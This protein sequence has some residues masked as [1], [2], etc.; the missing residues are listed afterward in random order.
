MKEI[1]L[2]MK[3]VEVKAKVRKLRTGIE[4]GQFD[5]EKDEMEII[6]VT[7]KTDE[8]LHEH[9]LGDPLYKK[10]YEDFCKQ[11]LIKEREN[12]I[13]RILDEEN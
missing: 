11:E 12:K 3:S 2:K 5:P 8:E 13:K 9:M 6:N 10:S 7:G 4:Y 1:N